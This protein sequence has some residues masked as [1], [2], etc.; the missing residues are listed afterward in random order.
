MINPGS[1]EPGRLLPPYRKMS[2]KSCGFG[3][4]KD[5]TSTPYQKVVFVSGIEIRRRIEFNGEKYK[6]AIRNLKSKG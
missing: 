1:V 4:N 3:V 6:S 2:I 5:R